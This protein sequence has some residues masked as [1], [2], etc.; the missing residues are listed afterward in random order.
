MTSP[1]DVSDQPAG[2][3]TEGGSYLLSLTGA[4]SHTLTREPGLARLALGSGAADLHVDPD[5][6]IDWTAFDPFATPAGSAW[7]RHLDYRGNDSGFFAW[8]RRRP[9]ENMSWRPVFD[10]VRR[11]DAAGA[12]IHSLFLKLDELTGALHLAL[13]D[14]SMLSIA[15]DLGRL[16]TEG[17]LPTTLAVLPPLGR[18]TD[19][20]VTLPD[21]GPLADVRSVI[22]SGKPLAR[23]I[24]LRSLAAFREITTLSLWGS[25]TDWDALAELSALETLEIRF[26]PDLEG[27]PSLDTWPR[28]ESFIAFNI[29]A[30][31]GKRLRSEMRARAKTRPWEGYTSV[32]KLREPDWWQTEYGRPF[33]GWDSRRAKRANAAYDA[34]VA[35]IAGAGTVD[36]VRDAVVAFIEGFNAVPGIETTEREDLGD[37]VVQFAALDRAVALGVNADIALEWFEQTRDF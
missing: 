4:H 25:F 7:P 35:A 15:G 19:G 16:T 32:V 28:L 3:V 5:D 31:A 29:D 11:V 9:I 36:D 27:M 2:S 10:D 21:L 22:L 37:A 34:A 26:A 23:P 20:A 6:A 14:T 33:S 1:R 24:S 18:G 17:P 13:P 8:A 30:G 12:G